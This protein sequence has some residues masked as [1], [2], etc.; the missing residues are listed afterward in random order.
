MMDNKITFGVDTGKNN[1]SAFDTLGYITRICNDGITI[2]PMKKNRL[3][4][5][6]IFNGNATIL[7]H[8]DNSKTIVKTMEGD[9]FD[10]VLGF[11]TAYFQKH[12]G[13]SK[14]KANDY[15]LEV[16]KK[17]EEKYGVK[18]ETPTRKYKFKVGDRVIGNKKAT[19]RYGITRE[20]WMGTVTAVYDK[21][22]ACDYLTLEYEYFDLLEEGKEK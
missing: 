2:E 21:Y 17:Y 13:L 6:Y 22:F 7:I 20:G 11:L 18:E 5:Q 3:P 14:N 9:D 8:E 10:P 12:S 1:D 19:E 15:L 16:R 4:K